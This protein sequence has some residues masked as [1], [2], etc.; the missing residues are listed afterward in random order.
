MNSTGFNVAWDLVGTVTHLGGAASAVIAA[1]WLVGRRR[2]I[3]PSANGLIAAVTTR[4]HRLLSSP[5]SLRIR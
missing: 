5:S 3:G 4:P 1:F 2:R